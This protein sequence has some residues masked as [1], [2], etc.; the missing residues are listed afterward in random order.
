MVIVQ[1]I[2][3]KCLFYLNVHEA[4][5]KL[6]GFT[7]TVEYNTQAPHFYILYEQSMIHSNAQALVV[8]NQTREMAWCVNMGDQ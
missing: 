4:S 1:V 5:F 3:G 6:F 8:Y 2:G 7:E